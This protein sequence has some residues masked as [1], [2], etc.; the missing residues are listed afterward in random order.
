MTLFNRS[1]T[2]LLAL[3]IGAVA[4]AEAEQ[5]RQDTKNTPVIVKEPPLPPVENEFLEPGIVIAPDK[6]TTIKEYKVNGQTYMI[7]ITPKKGIPY[8]LVDTDGDGNLETR[9]E[10]GPNILIPSWVIMRW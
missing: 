8:Y 3:L 5:P 1:I 4:L 10:I 7:V 2:I 9:H 6:K